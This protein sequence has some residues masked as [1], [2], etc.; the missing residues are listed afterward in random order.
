[1]LGKRNA[2]VRLEE[3]LK[4][5]AGRKPCLV[6]HDFQ[7]DACSKQF[8]YLLEADVED[9][10]EDA[11]S[12]GSAEFSLGRTPRAADERNDVRRRYALRRS[13]ADRL[14]RKLDRRP[15]LWRSAG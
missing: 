7:R 6:G 10:L 14:E 2:E 15:E 1:V 5:V 12:D 4:V 13:K 8:L 3:A 9:F 11:V